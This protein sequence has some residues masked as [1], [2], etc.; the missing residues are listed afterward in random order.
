MIQASSLNFIRLLR[1][2]ITPSVTTLLRGENDSKQSDEFQANMPAELKHGNNYL[3]NQSIQICEWNCALKLIK[4]HNVRYCLSSA[5][6]RLGICIINM[7][8]MYTLYGGSTG[9]GTLF[10][11]KED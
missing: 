6:N 3:S 11:P 5:L 8:Y 9:H 2:V 10:N 7:I 4:R 1:V